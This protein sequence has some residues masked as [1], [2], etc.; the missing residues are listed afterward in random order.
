MKM[1]RI[2]SLLII[3]LV[4]SSC[5]E[6][7]K[8]NTPGFQAQKDDVFWRAIDARAYVSETGTLTIEA[9]NQNE[10]LLLKAN[11]VNVGKYVLGTTNANN[12]ATY[13]SNFNDVELEYATIAVPGPVSNLTVATNGTGYNT[14]TSVATTGG[15]GSGLTVNITVNAS[16]QITAVTPSSRGNGYIAGDL[17]TVAGGNVNGKIRVSN[18]QN[19]NGEIEITKY[20]NVNMTVTG[21]FKFNAV[22]S[23]NSPLGGPF[24]NFQY[25]EF[26]KIPIYPSL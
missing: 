10:T 12:A 6:D 19:S 23:N 24:L 4:C 17:L 9:L 3:V 8:F 20:D 26:Y 25:G 14:A 21:K 13:S 11:S 18:V 16:G 15:T 2:L 5:Q 7:V 22:N 1:K